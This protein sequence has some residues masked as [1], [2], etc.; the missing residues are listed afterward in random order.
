MRPASIFLRR[1]TARNGIE[2][3]SLTVVKPASKVFL[4]FTTPTIAESNG[5]S[6]KSD[7]SW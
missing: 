2:P 5:V 4:A 3:T 1:S 6:L 7:I